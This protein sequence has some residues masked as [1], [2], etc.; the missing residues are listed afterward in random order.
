[1]TFKTFAA[2]LCAAGL[3]AVV[4][5]AG[6]PAASGLRVTSLRSPI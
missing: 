6:A 2:V 4:A 3:L 5:H 1:M